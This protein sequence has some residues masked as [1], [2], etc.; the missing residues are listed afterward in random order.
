MGLERLAPQVIEE[1]N[2]KKIEFADGADALA[3]PTLAV[4]EEAGLAVA[5]DTGITPELAAEGLA[6]EIVHRLQNMR[7]SAGFDIADYITTW[8]EGDNYVTQVFADWGDYIR[9]ETL[10]R[11]LLEGAPDEGAFTESYKL[12]AHEV[13]LGV[14]KD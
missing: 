2:V 5:M 11:Q 9:Q 6:R 1:L 10:S 4:S 12:A 8:F 7:R 3:V 14:K 13:R